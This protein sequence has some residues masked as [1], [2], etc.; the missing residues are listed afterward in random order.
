[1]EVNRVSTG[2]DPIDAVLDGGIEEKVVT[3]FYGGS[4]T[5]K[6]NL[7]VQI[8]AE[9]ATDGGS[10]VYIDTEGGFSPERFVQIAGEEQLENVEV[11]EPTSFEQQENAVERACE[12]EFDLLVVDSLVS[13]YR[14]EIDGDPQEVNQ[15]LSDMLS[16]LSR[17]AREREVPVVVT[18][19]VYS[20]FDSEEV[21]LVGR[22]V[23]R[24]WC[25]CLLRLEL[26]GSER[27]AVL[28]KH[29]SLPRG[30]KVRFSI[31]DEGLV[32]DG[33]SGLF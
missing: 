4:G 16:R 32:S 25:K 9:V 11:M 1:M 12:G 18:N 20:S 26:E 22:D 15:R 28:E 7:C 10:V 21:E 19:Q 2:S 3:N 24:Y 30:K 14:L 6:T 31:T 17:E 13:L 27:T 8:A 5:G 23:P 33:S 29:R